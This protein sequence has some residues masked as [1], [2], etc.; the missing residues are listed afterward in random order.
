MS[1]P[2]TTQQLAAKAHAI[3][4][5]CGKVQ[6]RG[7]HDLAV[8][9]RWCNRQALALSQEA[10]PTQPI[11]TLHVDGAEVRVEWLQPV[12]FA[13][14]IEVYDRPA[15]GLKDLPILVD[16]QADL[17]KIAGI[18]YAA[19]FFRALGH[20]LPIGESFAIVQRS[21]GAISIERRGDTAQAACMRGLHNVIQA[22][23]QESHAP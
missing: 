21:D 14:E 23:T 17:V 9:R 8:F 5:P 20:T 4:L 12:P 1:R 3:T 15:L 10:E 6:F 2:M 18:C 7:W 16:H 22:D 13:G 11:A 19:E